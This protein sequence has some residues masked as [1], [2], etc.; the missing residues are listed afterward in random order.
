VKRVLFSNASTVS[1]KCAPPSMKTNR[2]G[3]SGGALAAD[4]IGVGGGDG[5]AR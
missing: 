2:G 4:A 3:C 1:P 5:V